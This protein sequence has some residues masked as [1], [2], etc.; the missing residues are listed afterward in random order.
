MAAALVLL[1]LVA[2]VA[3]FAGGYLLSWPL[4]RPVDA[5]FERLAEQ[6][7]RP[8]SLDR[9]QK[10]VLRAAMGRVAV[11]VNGGVMA[12]SALE[13]RLA[14]DDVEALGDLG[15][16]FA[17]E[18]GAALAE[19]VLAQGGSVPRPP[20]VTIVEDESRPRS[21]PTVLA[22]FEAPT[23]MV[24]GPWNA[25]PATVVEAQPTMAAD[26]WELV[27]TV[28]SPESPPI[29]LSGAEVVLGRSRGADVTMADT[30]VSSRHAKLQRLP[31]GRWQVSD[32]GSTNGTFVRGQRIEA[33]A[34]LEPGDELRVGATTWRVE[35]R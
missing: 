30:T 3:V 11:G 25:G 28:P 10:R 6:A 23:E 22:R 8:L 1:V 19:R 31:D 7:P 21:R 16:W 33:P 35:Q 2:V 14:P 32:L 20:T 34:P 17:R 15:D 5:L 27:P 29:R 9:L 18:L 4:W 26:V 24:G 12:P 13:V